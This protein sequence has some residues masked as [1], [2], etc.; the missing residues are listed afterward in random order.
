MCG[1]SWCHGW[2]VD[3][4][5]ESMHPKW[6]RTAS[7]PRAAWTRLHPRRV[8]EEEGEGGGGELGELEVVTAGVAHLDLHEALE[9]EVL[10]QVERLHR[11]HV[12]GVRLRDHVGARLD[13]LRRD[14]APRLHQPLPVQLLDLGQHRRRQRL[15]VADEQRGL[16]LRRRRGAAAA[17]RPPPPAAPRARTSALRRQRV[18]SSLS[19]NSSSCSGGA[20]SSP[21]ASPS[22]GAAPPPPRGRRCRRRG[23]RPWRGAPSRGA[24]APRPAPPPRSPRRRS[25]ALLGERLRRRAREAAPRGT[26][27]GL[28]G[29]PHAHQVARRLVA[30]AAARAVAVVALAAHLARHAPPPPPRRLLRLPRHLVRR[31]AAAAAA[32]AITLLPL[33]RRRRRRV[34][35]GLAE[36]VL[37]RALHRVAAGV[38]PQIGPLGRRGALDLLRGHEAAGHVCSW[39]WMRWRPS[40]RWWRYPMYPV[41]AIASR[42]SAASSA[43]RPRDSSA[44][45]ASSKARRSARRARR[46]RRA[47]QPR[48]FAACTAGASAADGGASLSAPYTRAR[49][50]SSRDAPSRGRPGRRAAALPPSEAAMPRDH[51]GGSDAA[52]ARR[53]RCFCRRRGGRRRR[54][55]LRRRRAALLG[56]RRC[57]RLLLLLLL[58]FAVDQRVA[59]RQQQPG[60]RVLLRDDEGGDLLAR[61]RGVERRR[62]LPRH[63]RRVAAEPLD[64]V[65]RRRPAADAVDDRLGDAQRA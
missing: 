2:L 64:Q 63:L 9:L 3:P 33:L 5:N 28:E 31:R 41:G 21:S 35:D 62:V 32:A 59:R 18:P 54:R 36:A 53:R 30:A 6:V 43:A 8:L 27:L 17:R 22:A 29:R 44:R 34:L 11:V 40:C 52:D 19:P 45:S 24:T 61:P 25:A 58:Q 16:F 14:R 51:V 20:A 38:R 37:V 13:L 49:S 42:S 60:R 48:C 47:R 65:A 39:V 23:V 10:L 7:S 56:R 50:D 1:P 55:R 4:G 46:L 12:V 15:R 26:L 57:R